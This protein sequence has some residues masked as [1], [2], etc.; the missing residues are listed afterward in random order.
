MLKFINSMHKFIEKHRT[1]Q[2]I[3]WLPADFWHK[4]YWLLHCIQ[5]CA[6]GLPTRDRVTEPV[7][8]QQGGNWG[9]PASE[10]R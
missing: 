3:G 7:D 10:R 2:K 9:V 4:H 1:E 5:W 8:L 6:Q